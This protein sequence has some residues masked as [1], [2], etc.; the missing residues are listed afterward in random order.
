GRRDLLTAQAQDALARSDAIVGYSGYF[1]AIEDLTADK[2]CHRLPLGQER[3]RGRLAVEL[4]AQGK[5]VAVISSGDPG[6]YAMAG[7]VLEATETSEIAK[8]LE[9]CVIPGISAI[10]AAAAL[11]GAPLGHDFAVISLSDLLTPWQV[12]EKRL[13]AAAEADFVLVLLNPRSRQR[14]WQL[15]RAR[16]ILLSRRDPNTPL[17]FVRNA[18]RLGQ[19]VHAT[20]LK[21]L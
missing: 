14:T 5:T 10:N 6:I 17:G 8:N 13:Q 7:M 21:D 15:A 18:F 19:D 11:L 9:V 12:I 4:A 3:E 20:T 16:K 2:E 1:D